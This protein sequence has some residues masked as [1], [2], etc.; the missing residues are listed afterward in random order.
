[1]PVGLRISLLAAWCCGHVACVSGATPPAAA[2][3]AAVSGTWQ[4]SVS[5]QGGFAGADERFTASDA[6]DALLIVDAV[7]RTET[8]VTFSS[9]DK[10]ELAQS[11]AVRASTPDIDLR[12]SACRDCILFEMTMTTERTGKPRRVRY[13]STTMD[14][15]PDAKLIERIIA[16]GRNGIA[17]KKP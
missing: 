3:T 13:D 9:A 17:S 15:S 4:L 8:A 2:P 14:A 16:I 1:M 11:V 7:R 5:R 6:S 10:R 12:S